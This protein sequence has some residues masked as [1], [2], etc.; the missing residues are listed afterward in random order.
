MSRISNFQIITLCQLAGGDGF[1]WI[2]VG[3][4]FF[5]DRVQ[6]LSKKKIFHFYQIYNM[7]RKLMYVV[8]ALLI[9]VFGLFCVQ[10]VSAQTGPYL[11]L[12][13]GAETG[14]GRQDVRLTAARI[15]SAV[16][17]LLGTIVVVIMLYAGYEWMTA[18]GNDDK[19][20][21]A[22]KRMIYAVIGLAIIL[23]AYAITRFVSTQLY[24][25][26]TGEYYSPSI[27]NF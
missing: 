27:D 9:G 7:K 12:E 22:K 11:G 16:M 6:A 23:S 3:E 14:L 4:K 15:I 26:T 25:A 13:Y 18:G 21:E 1:D 24:Q 19:V 8:V 17:G 10:T 5:A 2:D 20:G